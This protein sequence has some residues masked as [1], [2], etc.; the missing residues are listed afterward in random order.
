MAVAQSEIIL[1]KLMPTKNI[2]NKPIPK[3]NYP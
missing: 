2:K 1:K 3:T